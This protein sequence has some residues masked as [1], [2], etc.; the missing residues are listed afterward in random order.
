MGREG[1]ISD[2]LN[3]YPLENPRWP[4]H[5]PGVLWMTPHVT[6]DESQEHD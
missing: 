1:K 2:S 4:H 6:G 3:N 5:L